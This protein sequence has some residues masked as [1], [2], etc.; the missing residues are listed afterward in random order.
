MVK[1]F[2]IHLYCIREVARKCDNLKMRKHLLIF[3]ICI[4]IFIFHSFSLDFTKINGLKFLCRCE[5]TTIRAVPPSLNRSLANLHLSSQLNRTVFSRGRQKLPRIEYTVRDKP[6]G[7][8]VPFLSPCSIFT[9]LD[10]NAVCAFFTGT[11]V[12]GLV[13]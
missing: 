13:I 4:C 3:L 5:T 1:L 2:W 10:P 8:P 6:I 11:L 7:F 12:T 9:L